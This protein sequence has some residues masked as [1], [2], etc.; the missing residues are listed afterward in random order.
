MQGD[1]LCLLLHFCLQCMGV[2]HQTP[3]LGHVYYCVFVFSVRECVI[4][5]QHL[6]VFIIALLSSAYGSVS[7]DPNTWQVGPK[8]LHVS[9]SIV[10]AGRAQFFN[11]E[12]SASG[13]PPPTYEVRAQSVL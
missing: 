1:R 6:A 3:T 12:C 2:L 10:F 5:P 8:F 11:L 4:G 7:S 13:N 9:P